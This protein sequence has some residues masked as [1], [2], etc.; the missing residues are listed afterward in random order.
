MLGHI[1][2]LNSMTEIKYPCRRDDGSFVV[3]ARFHF[4]DHSVLP[5]VRDY[6]KAWISANRT[7]T[8][9]WRSD[10]IRVEKMDYDVEFLSDPRLEELSGESLFSVF[11]EARSSATRWKDWG[12]FLVHDISTV[13][14]DIDFERFE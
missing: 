1:V 4:T 14:P 2:A 11:L 10:V 13:F 3:V 12:V 7:W 5:L 8:R 6:L 9:I